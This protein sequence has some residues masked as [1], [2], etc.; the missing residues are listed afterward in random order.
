[1]SGRLVS[2]LEGGD[3]VERLADCVEQHLETLLDVSQR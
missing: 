1:M 3:N 2:R